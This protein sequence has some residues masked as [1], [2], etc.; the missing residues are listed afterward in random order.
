MEL[1]AACQTLGIVP[2]KLSNDPVVTINTISVHT[3]V[4]HVPW[5]HSS[6]SF[7]NVV[8]HSQ[9]SIVQSQDLCIVSSLNKHTSQ[10]FDT[11]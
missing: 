2:P 4:D 3:L 7:Q 11:F 6:I 9:P 8:Y 10:T 5:Y 1:A